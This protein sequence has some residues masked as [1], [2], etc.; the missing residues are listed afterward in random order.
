MSSDGA[1]REGKKACLDCFITENRPEMGLQRAG[2]FIHYLQSEH[3]LRW[4]KLVKE[5]RR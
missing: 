2:Q 5:R 1:S 4:G 3:P